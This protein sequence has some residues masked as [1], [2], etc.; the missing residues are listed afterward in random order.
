MKKTLNILLLPLYLCVGVLY[1]QDFSFEMYFED[2]LGNK[3]TLTFGYDP[4][5]TD[6]IDAS[7]GEIDVS[8]TPWSNDFEVRISDYNYMDGQYHTD[9]YDFYSKK[10]IQLKSCG[11]SNNLISIVHV[12]NPNYPIL[13]S[14]DSTLFIDPCRSNSLITG[15][16]PGGWFD[17]VW[18]G[19]QT[20]NMLKEHDS[21]LVYEPF[22]HNVNL[23]GDTTHLFYIT[24]ANENQVFVGIQEQTFQNKKELIK[25]VDLFGRETEEQPNTTL[26][27]VYDDGTTEKIF[28]VE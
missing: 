14:W 24:I 25:I 21:V 27:Y 1:G 17:A 5:A 2:A 28:R 7:F 23:Q 3:D 22:H 16:N 10:Q 19:E 4:L 6:G 20:V 13:I 8:A 11:I 9:T 26:I 15:W 18:G 12:N